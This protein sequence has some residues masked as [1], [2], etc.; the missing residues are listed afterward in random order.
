[1]A[2]VARIP[3]LVAAVQV[4][5]DLGVVEETLVVAVIVILV[6]FVDQTVAAEILVV[7]FLKRI[8]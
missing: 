6:A 7:L 8:C 1:M 5:S 3:K 2:L 4:S